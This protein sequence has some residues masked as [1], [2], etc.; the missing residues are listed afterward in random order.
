MN[1]AKR[2]AKNT[3]FLYARMAITVFISLY[4]TRLVL[5]ALGAADFGIFNVVGGA[6]AML[7]FLNASMAA[8]TQRFMS[9][10]LGE[11]NMEKLKQV[12]NVSVSLHLIIA[13]VLFIVLEVVGYF[14]FNGILNI[15]VDRVHSAKVVYQFMVASTL[16]T[17]ISVPYDAAI[18]ANENMLLLAI[19][20]VTEAILKL[21]I[22]FAIVITKRDKLILYGGL[23]AGVTIVHLI[24]RRMYCHRRYPECILNPRTFFNEKL[25]REMR[26]FAGWSLVGSSSSM[27]SNYGQ[28]IVLN[29]FFGP[30]ANAAQGIANQVS[31]QLGVFSVTMMKALNPVL[32]KSAG[33]GN[34]DLMIKATYTGSKVSFFLLVILYVPVLIEMPYVFSIWLQHVPTYAVVFCRLL[35][36]QN[37]V[38]QL[39]IPLNTTIFAMGNIRAYQIWFSIL[40]ISTLPICYLLFLF[41]LPPYSLYLV[42]L[43]YAFCYG[44]LI[45][46]FSSLT[47]GFSFLEFIKR[48]AVIACCVFLL[49][50]SIGSSP[51][52]FMQ[53]GLLRVFVV[54]VCSTTTLLLS[55]WLFGLSIREKLEVK[56][57]MAAFLEKFHTKWLPFAFISSK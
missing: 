42:F 18:N 19:L 15:P 4:A 41:G 21:A 16:F 2:I 39:F 14:L 52:L 38:K 10:T 46:Y 47:C 20:G 45:L 30:I 23:M 3:A 31:G 40:T 1:E 57:V 54:G 53:S 11:G 5:S 9:F 24:A 43:V 6:I 32:A 34:R 27:L 26:R 29:V 7:G 51:I 56:R 49:T 17:V 13:L 36:I 48:V 37:L 50:A 35:L 12:F 28:G 33:A 44:A 8:A 22:A 25:F 55:V